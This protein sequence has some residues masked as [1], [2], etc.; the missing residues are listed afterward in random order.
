LAKD[1]SPEEIDRTKAPTGGDTRRSTTS[2]RM[3]DG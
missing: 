2:L 1:G 3:A